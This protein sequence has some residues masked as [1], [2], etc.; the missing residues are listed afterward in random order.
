MS[1][2]AEATG[3]GRAT[4]YKYFPD[5]ES[6]LLAWHERHVNA[7]LDRLKEIRSKETVGRELP[8]VLDAYAEIVHE[9]GRGAL[10]TFLH[11]DAHVAHAQAHL[12]EFVRDLIAEEAK[13]GTVRGD[14]SPTELAAFVLH[15]LE[16]AGDAKSVSGARRLSAIT[17]EALRPP[18]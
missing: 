9:R 5:V 10:V 18:S 12:R 14:V 15:A 8:A 11:Q 3:I 2:I 13:S 16:A 1:G 6:I 17:L 7:H 4:L